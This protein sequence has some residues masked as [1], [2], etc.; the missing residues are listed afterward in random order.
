M[1][2]NKFTKVVAVAGAGGFV[3]AEIVKA[4]L[5]LGGFEVRVLVRA[6]SVSIL[7]IS[8]RHSQFSN[9]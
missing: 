9:F 6:S 1:S 5:E 4:L 8:L 7:S 3:G 2:T